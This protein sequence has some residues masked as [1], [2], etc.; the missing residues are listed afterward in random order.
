MRLAASVIGVGLIAL[1]GG[2]SA[3]TLRIGL[4]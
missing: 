2:A 1:V 4:Q 3:Q